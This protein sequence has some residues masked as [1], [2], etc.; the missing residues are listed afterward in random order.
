MKTLV[1]SKFKLYHLDGRSS[2]RNLPVTL[3]LIDVPDVIH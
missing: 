2:N 3:L 1:Q